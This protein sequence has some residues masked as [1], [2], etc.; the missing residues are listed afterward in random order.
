MIHRAREQH[1]T[2]RVLKGLLRDAS[3]SRSV[4]FGAR[5]AIKQRFLISI[6]WADGRALAQFV[7][8]TSK[9]IAWRYAW[10]RAGNPEDMGSVD[11]ASVQVIR[12]A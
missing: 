2:R 9:A 7:R 3:A 1:V 5:R 12:A 4:L 8:A 6:V 10:E 11:I